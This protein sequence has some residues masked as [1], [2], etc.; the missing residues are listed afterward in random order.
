MKDKDKAV[1][2]LFIGKVA[3]IIGFE[4]AT[5]LL[6]QAKEEIKGNCA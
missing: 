4:K 3:S 2:Q 1:Y 5:E 6:K